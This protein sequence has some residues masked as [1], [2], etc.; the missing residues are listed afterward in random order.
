M[1]FTIPPVGVVAPSP[2]WVSAWSIHARDIPSEVTGW[3]A[4]VSMSDVMALRVLPT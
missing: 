1:I 3:E 2:V 4:C